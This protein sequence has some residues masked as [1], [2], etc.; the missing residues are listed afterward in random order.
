MVQIH[1]A[2]DR[3]VDSTDS[4]SL[5]D[6]LVRSHHYLGYQNLIGHRLKYIAFMGQQPVAA[7]SFSAPA[8]KLAARD[9]YIG[10]SAAP[11]KNHLNHPASN[12]RFLILPWVKVPNLAS[13]VLSLNIA[14]LIK[15]WPHYFNHNLLVEA[16]SHGVY[17]APQE[18][19]QACLRA[20]NKSCAVVFFWLTKFNWG[21]I[22][23][24]FLR[25][26]HSL[27]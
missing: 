9:Q 5:W 26:H 8:L 17:S 16:Q 11:K 1:R 18:K 27:G 19:S 10:W 6:H 12:S 3:G 7:L 24:D 4:E 25:D 20:K 15:D 23:S 2:I 21:Y 13:H 14:R 22:V